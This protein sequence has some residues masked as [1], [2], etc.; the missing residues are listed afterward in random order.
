MNKPNYNQTRRARIKKYEQ[1]EAKRAMKG[2]WR[3]NFL[4]F[5]KTSHL[6]FWRNQSRLTGT[7]FFKEYPELRKFK[8]DVATK[9]G[10]VRIYM[11][12]GLRD[13]FEKY[14]RAK[15][16]YRDLMLSKRA[17]YRTK[18]AYNESLEL[19]YHAFVSLKFDS[20]R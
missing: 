20:I 19:F 4:A 15:T 14:F 1:T 5:A 2:D 7:D 16:I 17:K 18:W 13:G 6:R 9:E 8:A 12:K 11:V 10:F 3:K